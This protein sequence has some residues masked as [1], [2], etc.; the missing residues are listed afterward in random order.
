MIPEMTVEQLK[1]LRDRQ[2]PLLILDVRREEEWEIAHL[3]GAVLVPL[4]ELQQRVH[5]VAAAAKGRKAVVYCH[6]GNRSKV[7][8]ALLREAGVEASSLKGGID[9]WSV[10]IDDSL[11]RY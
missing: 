2:E 10:R 4:H 5:E 11:Q 8:A 3:S 9:A 1:R 7:G 6:H